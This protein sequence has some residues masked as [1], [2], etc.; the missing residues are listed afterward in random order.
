MSSE[1]L[2]WNVDATG[3]RVAVV[4]A[5]FNYEIT[6][7]LLAGA[8]AALKQAGAADADIK[9]VHVPGAFELP[10]AAKALAA[11]FDA[12]VAL[13]AVVRGDTPHFDYVAGEAARGIQQASLETL[14]PIAFGVLTTETMQQALER[15]GGTSTKTDAGDLTL[16][17]GFDAANTAIE[18]A[19]LLNGIR[20]KA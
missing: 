5:R 10:V 18:M 13:G 6:S 2:T 1:K 14:K 16:N 4:V 20:S 11:S 19:H 9:V 12:V 3:L 17:K 15:A 8:L 7:R